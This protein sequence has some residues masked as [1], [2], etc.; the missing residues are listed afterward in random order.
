MRI[1]DWSSDVCSSDLL[2]IP[3]GLIG[4]V[5][6]VNLRGLEN[7]VY[8]QIGLLTTMGLAAKNAIMMIEFAEQEERKGKRVIEAAVEA[9]RIR[10]RPILMTSFAFIFRVMRLAMPTRPE[11]ISR[12]PRG[13]PGSGR[14]LI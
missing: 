13:T 1:S 6:A 4:A 12:R 11:P 10:L 7:D 9:A 8:L 2:V 3:L 14:G 5:F